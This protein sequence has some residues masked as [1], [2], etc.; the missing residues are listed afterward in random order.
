[1]RTHGAR[2]KMEE[3]ELTLIDEQIKAFF[4][5]LTRV[6]KLLNVTLLEEYHTLL[7]LLDHCLSS[8]VPTRV[9]SPTILHT[10]RESSTPRLIVS[11][12]K[13]LVDAWLVHMLQHGTLPTGEI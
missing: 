6:E 1:M 10:Q 8:D 4:D 2:I 3:Y 9:T 7:S 12:H 13:V 11:P 5:V